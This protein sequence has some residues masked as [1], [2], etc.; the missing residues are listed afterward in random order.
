MGTNEIFPSG[1]HEQLSIGFQRA[2]SDTALTT[3]CFE[4]GYLL[5]TAAILHKMLT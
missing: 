2:I 5:K 3:K 1:I 4:T